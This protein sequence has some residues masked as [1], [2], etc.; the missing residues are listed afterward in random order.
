MYTIKEKVVMKNEIR[1]YNG[2]VFFVDILG[3]SA[4]TKG[5]IKDITVSDFEAW[6]LNSENEQN[7]SCLAATILVEFRDV[8][9]QLRTR[10]PNIHVAQ[11][12][13]CAF[14][15]SDDVI[16]LMQSLH[17]I[18]WT[19]IEQ[20]AILCRGGVAF[21]E[22]VE[23][24]NVDNNIGAFIVGD[25]VTRAV[26]NEGRLKGP[27]VTMGENFPE[28]LWHPLH[29]SVVTIQLASDI[30]HPNESEID[31]SVVDEYRWYL[32]DDTL[33]PRTSFLAFEDMIELTKNRLRLANILRFHPRM[34][35]NSRGEEGLL[36]LRAGVKSMSANRLLG[37]LH[38][39]ETDSVADGIRKQSHLDSANKRVVEDS[40]CPLSQEQEWETNFDDLD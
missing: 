29:S 23:V 15:W 40:Y 33:I 39:F 6:G 18:M 1:R 36:Q 14:I 9:R 8:L 21:G 11:L 28:A 5:Q 30:F 27:R 31:L 25:A 2:A 4:L 3:F 35:W 37:V 32:C 34:G 38:Y 10:Y 17:F 20:K 24:E 19:M 22:I 7:N 12:S 16:L 26:K 13:D